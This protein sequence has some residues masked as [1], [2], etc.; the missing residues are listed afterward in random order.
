MESHFVHL[1]VHTE[2]SLLDGSITISDLIEKAVSRG[3]KAVAITDTANLSGVLEFYLKAKEK[4]IRPIIGAEIFHE[5]SP[6]TMRYAASQGHERPKAGAFHLVLL[7][8][9]LSGYKN[10]IKV[11]SNGYFETPAEVPIVKEETLNRF[12][13]DLIALSGCLKGEFS[14][15][16]GELKQTSGRAAIDFDQLKQL[17]F[18]TNVR[19]AEHKKLSQI[20]N[21][22]SEHVQNMCTCYGRG[23]YYVEL[24]DN[25]LPEQK[26]L[27]PSLVEAARHFNLPL[28]ATSDAHYLDEDFEEAHAILLG[29]K[30]ELTLSSM[31]QRIKGARFHL[32]SDPEIYEIYQGWPEAVANTMM[33]AEQCNVEFKFGKY[34]LPHFKVEGREETTEESLK[35][36]AKE[37]LDVRLQNLKL[38]YGSSFSEDVQQKYRDRLENELE[39]IIKMGFPGYFLIVQDF[40]N[41]AKKHGIRVGPGRGSGAGSLVAYSLNITDL[42]PIPY[43]LLFERFLNPERVSMPDFDVDF[44]QERRDEVINY[45]T[46]RYGSENV[47]Q[48]TTFG[49]MLAK[50]AVRDVGRVMD[51]SYSK[52]D[53]IAKLIP[54]ELGITLNDALERE[55]RLKE[56]ISKDPIIADLMNIAKKLEGLN[57]H[58]SVHAAGVVISDGPMTEHVPVYKAENGSAITQFE[59]A[60]VDKIGLIKFDF[61]GLKTLTVI[62]KTI[63]LINAKKKDAPFDLSRISLE[64]PKIYAE[65]SK[66]HT[67]GVFQMESQGMQQVIV[68]IQPSKFEDLIATIALFRPGPMIMMDDFIERKHGRQKIDYLVPQLEPILRDTYGCFVY[69]EEVLQAAA[70]LANYRLGEADLLRRAMGKKKPEE[71]AQQKTRFISGCITNGISE[72]K[73]GEIFELMAKFAEYGFN[74]SHS[75]AYALICYQTAYLKVHYPEEFMAA[76]MTCDTDNTD[77]I[78]KYVEE[79]RR[80]GFKVLGPNLNKSELFYDTPASKII[81]FGLAT[82]KGIGLASVSPLMENRAEHGPFKNIDDLAN[83]INLQRIGKKT[84][85]LLV[86]AGAF[87]DLDEIAPGRIAKN[88]H[89]IMEA[90]QLMV[91]KSEASHEAKSMGQRSL[92]DVF[93]PLVDTKDSYTLPAPLPLSSYATEVRPS[94]I[95]IDRESLYK[96]KK[97]LGTFVSGHPID[98]YTEDLRLFSKASIKQLMEMN[99]QKGEKKQIALVALLTGVTERLS[100]SNQRLVYLALEDSS[101]SFE[102]LMFDRSRPPSFPPE[103][104]PVIVFGNVD[105]SFDGIATRM[106]VDQIQDLEAY[107]QMQIKNMFIHISPTLLDH[108]NGKFSEELQYIGEQPELKRVMSDLEQVIQSSPGETPIK[109]ILNLKKAKLTIGMN[110]RKVKVNDG[111]LQE[112]KKLKSTQFGITYSLK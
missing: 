107:R 103:N 23:H 94:S 100:K 3:Q 13:G 18:E 25:N 88:R 79:C 96:E 2:Y 17:S 15:L 30:N 97:L 70:V 65:I 51:I 16:I 84:L 85:E 10:L 47:A 19:S 93:T 64:D 24:I 12:S 75:A 89:E 109:L 101:G 111:F 35:R 34:Y 74:K 62:D 45:V 95:H 54:N 32:F 52:V 81:R 27:L 22:L 53:K 33:I 26:A 50:A 99:I 55:P 92:F 31:R 110:H 60:N 105:K 14:Y 8:K 90:V 11:V 41:W 106:V 63:K 48:I 6:S 76:L 29:V 20:Y 86:Q 5:G 80:L 68:K 1:H 104:T 36:L 28:V 73:A 66:A 67:V 38:L 83:R 102:A 91:K 57:R 58:A 21:A 4:G 43:N 37:G 42:D 39:I 112:L 69:Q 56:E 71:M 9:N 7:S 44:C 59:M 82:I 61:L 98:A 40:I 77:K 46:E 108:S 72:Q 49:K 78:T 87:D